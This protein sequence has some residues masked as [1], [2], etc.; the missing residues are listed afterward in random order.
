[1]CWQQQ[2]EQLQLYGVRLQCVLELCVLVP[3]GPC[4]VL[5]KH[6][7]NCTGNNLFTFVLIVRKC[8]KNKLANGCFCH[9]CLPLPSFY[10]LCVYVRH[11]GCQMSTDRQRSKN[12]SF[13]CAFQPSFVAAAT[14]INFAHTTEIT[15]LC[16]CACKDFASF[17]L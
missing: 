1:M 17:V 7:I 8:P 16:G 10:D 12:C 9:H 15:K 6:N 11:S 3:L 13:F 2:R 4:W 14:Q 5:S